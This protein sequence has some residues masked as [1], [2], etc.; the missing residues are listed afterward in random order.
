MYVCIVPLSLAPPLPP[1][2][3]RMTRSG[4]SWVEI[5]WGASPNATPAVSSFTLGYRLVFETVW[6][7]VSDIEPM[8]YNISGLY[9]NARYLVR[10]SA[11]SS[12]GMGNPSDEIEVVTQQGGACVCV[13][14][15]I[16][17]IRV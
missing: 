11:E 10:V 6:T 16:F 15:C 8:V 7:T 14:A 3:V 4:S 1:A 13:C 12:S 2:N 5:L 17:V 9:P